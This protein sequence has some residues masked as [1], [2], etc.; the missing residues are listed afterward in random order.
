MPRPPFKKL[1]KNVADFPQNLKT[2]NNVFV[3]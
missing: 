1:G 3:V 2:L